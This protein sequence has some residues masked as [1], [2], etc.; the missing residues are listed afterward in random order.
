M[1]ASEMHAGERVVFVCIIQPKRSALLQAVIAMLIEKDFAGNMVR[2]ASA[3]LQVVMQVLIVM[4]S[5][6]RTALNQSAL[7]NDA[8]QPSMQGEGVSNT[9]VVRQKCAR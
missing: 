3:L 2:G 8:P 5:A 7:R 9:A 6:Q 4:V 1:R